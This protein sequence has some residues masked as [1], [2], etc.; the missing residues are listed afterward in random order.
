M[1]VRLFNHIL[2]A[3]YHSNV[4]RIHLR[5]GSNLLLKNRI[6][7]LDLRNILHRSIST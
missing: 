7:G 6:E 5:G 1:R 3:N 4:F 2:K